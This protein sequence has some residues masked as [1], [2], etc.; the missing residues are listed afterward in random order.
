VLGASTLEESNIKMKKE[1][2][3]CQEGEHLKKKEEP[4]GCSGMNN[5]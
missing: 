3:Y 5:L 4:S 1:Q 2:R